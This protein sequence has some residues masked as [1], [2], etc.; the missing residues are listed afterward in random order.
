VVE[1][2]CKVA[3]VPIAKLRMAKIEKIKPFPEG[4]APD[5]DVDL[6]VDDVQGQDAE[7]VLL[8]DR[9]GGTVLEEGALGHLGEHL[10]HGVGPVL[11]FHLRVGKDVA[12]VAHELTAEEEVGEVDLEQF[13]KSQ[14]WTN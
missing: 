4:N 12:A 5:E 11:G 3:N 14:F 9:A 10:G 13:S 7:A 1:Q 8:L 2:S 6:L